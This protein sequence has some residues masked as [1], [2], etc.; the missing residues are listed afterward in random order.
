MQTNF[1][2]MELSDLAGGNC[3]GDA[4]GDLLVRGPVLHLLEPHRLQCSHY[5]KKGQT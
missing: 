4:V 1:Q 5:D 3:A 2:K